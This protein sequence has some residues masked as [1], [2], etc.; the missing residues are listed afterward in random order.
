MSKISKKQL[1]HGLMIIFIG[2]F[3]ISV[4]IIMP[5]EPADLLHRFVQCF[6]F[7]MGTTAVCFPFYYKIIEICD[8]INKTS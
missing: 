8:G 1:I 3:V 7:S 2:S 4:F 6:S 5:K